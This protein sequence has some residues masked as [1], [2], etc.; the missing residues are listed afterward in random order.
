MVKCVV[1]SAVAFVCVLPAVGQQPAAAPEANP[2]GVEFALGRYV[3]TFNKHD[4]DALAALWTSEGLY[5]DN[6]TGH[7]T[8]G[9]QA[10]AADF[11][12]LFAA[13]PN[14]ALSGHVEGVRSLGDGLAL[15][16]GTSI[17][18]TPDGDSSASTYSAI[19]KRVEGK[20]L[21][22]SVHESPLPTPES[23]REALE[24]VH[25][26]IVLGPTRGRAGLRRHADHR[27]GPAGQAD[28]IVDVQLRW[29]VRGGIVVAQPGR[30]AGANLANAA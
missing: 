27:L 5:V 17:T 8:E 30:V 18:A 25:R 2:D 26:A 16:D 21:L 3:V 1:F 20:W 19:F 9:R 12:E 22:D 7:R 14:V 4:A 28:S 15:V 24:L 23:P 11:R 10:L 29:F 13:S 6:A